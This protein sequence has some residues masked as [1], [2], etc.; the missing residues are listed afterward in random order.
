MSLV[1]LNITCDQCGKSLGENEIA[2]SA[3]VYGQ[4]RGWVSV[5]GTDVLWP[6]KDEKDGRDFCSNECLLS[7]VKDLVE[8]NGE[9]KENVLV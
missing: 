2:N 5:R 3:T 4:L 1:L 8:K 7:F 9:G 6:P